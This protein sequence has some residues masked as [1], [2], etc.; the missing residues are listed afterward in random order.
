VPAGGSRP[1]VVFRES[2]H[3][4][5]IRRRIFAGD[6]KHNAAALF[7]A[8]KMVAMPLIRDPNYILFLESFVANGKSTW[9]FRFALDQ[10]ILP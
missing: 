4:L 9:L 7:V 1:F 6:A 8:D 10:R 5:G 2:I 3:R